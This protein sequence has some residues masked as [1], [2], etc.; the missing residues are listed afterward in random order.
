MLIQGVKIDFLFNLCYNKITTK[1]LKEPSP[2]ASFAKPVRTK[3]AV[4]SFFAYGALFAAWVI[5]Q[6]AP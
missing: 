1:P 3:L 6:L 4:V 5:L 2:Q